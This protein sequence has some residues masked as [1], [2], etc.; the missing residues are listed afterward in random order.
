M[1]PIARNIFFIV[2]FS[3]LNH[4]IVLGQAQIGV[5]WEF[6]E[7]GNTEGWIIK[8]SFETLN[9]ENGV[10]SVITT[11]DVS[12]YPSLNSGSFNIKAEDYGFI[13][14]RVR[15][16][17]AENLKISWT[18]D[19]GTG[20]YTNIEL[21]R[22]NEFHTY[23][24]PVF[25]NSFWKDNIVQFT[26]FRIEDAPVGSLIEID[27]IRIMHTGPRAEIENLK[28]ERPVIKQGVEV[29][30]LA[31]IKNSGDENASSNYELTLPPEVILI[32]GD[33]QSNVQDIQPQES[34]TIKWIV[35]SD[36]IG[37]H[38]IN[39]SLDVTEG[40]A[41][42]T[43]AFIVTDTHWQQDDFL[44]SAWSPPYAWYT[45]PYDESVFED[46]KNANFDVALWARPQDELIALF[47]Q[48]NLKYYILVTHLLGGDEYLREPSS[49]IAPEITP[50]MLSILDPVIEKYRNNP[51]MIGYH[52]CDE[53]Y[54]V[55]FGNIGK[56]VNY[57]RERDPT[58][59]CFVNIWPGM[60][61]FRYQDYIEK[62]L[63]ITK[64]PILSYDR[65]IFHNGYDETYKFFSNIQIIRRNAL[66]YDIPFYNII[67]AIGT[68]GT[69][70]EH[71][72]W[73]TPTISQLNWQAYASLAYGVKGLIWFHWHGNW[74]VTGY[75]NSAFT[76]NAIQSVNPEIKVL[77]Q[78]MLDLKSTGVYHNHPDHTTIPAF[79]GDT[80]IRSVSDN[81]NLVIGM[82]KDESDNDYVMLM[83]KDYYN[84]TTV[85]ISSDYH[86]YFVKEF[87][88]E[89]SEWEM[90]IIPVILSSS[91]SH[92]EITIEPGSGKLLD[93]SNRST[94]VADRIDDHYL[95]SNLK[96]TP[97]PFNRSTKISYTL[98]ENSYVTLS[99]YNSSGQLVNVLEK[100]KYQVASKKY[101]Y[102]WNG[103]D[104]QDKQ[105]DAGLYF[106][107]LVT[108]SSQES[109]KI[110]K[111]Y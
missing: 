74:G 11:S 22:D 17:G 110:L 77:G 32:D 55:T 108:N 57:I 99:V 78:Q 36:I 87:N 29:P 58:R 90:I 98:T 109:V 53:P 42:S 19:T 106:V 79:E 84:S 105:L 103:R 85:Q 43:I 94:F 38:T 39:L 24:K 25:L 51:N 56:V 18:T 45:P 16:N 60:D 91:G 83:N 23:N 44:L 33:L 7:N 26:S 5:A 76:Y 3:L 37:N 12:P 15:T 14:L 8:D 81:S 64:L 100:N 96:S 52:I 89:T 80:L 21:Y 4:L 10:L 75:P 31:F 41:D 68:D 88:P 107:R 72:D 28:V 9:V 104:I 82:F 86:I 49:G 54:E 2:S 101:T 59:E 71:L 65:Y 93:L 35:K 67:Q 111:L 1:N 97:N 47:E 30:L 20:L 66:R 50:A 48:Y 27:F 73:R 63:D 40:K 34:D 13:S 6:N 46:Y 102:E 69:I 70:E 61:D 62:L 92:F 95:Q